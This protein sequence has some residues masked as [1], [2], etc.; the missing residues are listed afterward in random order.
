MRGHSHRGLFRHRH[1]GHH[2]HHHGHHHEGGR[3]LGQGDLRYL[4]LFLLEEKPRHGYELIKALE[5]LSM[6]AYS[7]SPGTIYPTLTYLSEGGFATATTEENKNLYTISKQ[8]VAL[9]DEN[10]EFVKELYERFSHAG[11][12]MS[13]MRHWMGRE[14]NEEIARDEKSPIRRA[15]HGLKAELFSFVDATKAKQSQVGEIIERAAAEIKK[16]RD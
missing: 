9:L 12:R 5:E 14:E 7:P 4:I 3:I 16:L 8:G 11:E 15:M 10:R 13:R 1:R 6:G 2:H